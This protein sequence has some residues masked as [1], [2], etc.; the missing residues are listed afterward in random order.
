MGGDLS[1]FESLGI[2]FEHG[3]KDKASQCMPVPR[4]PLPG[5]KTKEGCRRQRCPLSPAP[6]EAMNHAHKKRGSLW[7]TSSGCG[8]P[9]TR[10]SRSK[11]IPT[12]CQ[13]NHW[14][15]RSDSEARLTQSAGDKTANT[16]HRLAGL[17]VECWM[18]KLSEAP[19][20]NAHL[21]RP[22]AWPLLSPS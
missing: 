9:L 22:F 4:A 20:S 11:G 10:V 18:P 19:R 2:R 13:G 15:R 21:P 1:S 17:C 3:G 16:H 6:L 12:F 7:I 8:T 5:I 14:K